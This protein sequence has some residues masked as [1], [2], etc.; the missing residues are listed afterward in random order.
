[1]NKVILTGRLVRE[2]EVRFSA[3][4]KIVYIFALAVQRATQVKDQP[5]ADFL[6]CVAFGTTGEQMQKCDL[7]KGMK[8]LVDGELRIESYTDKSGNKRLATKV[9][10]YRF[11]MLETKHSREIGANAGYA[12][13]EDNSFSGNGYDPVEDDSDVPF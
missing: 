12:N 1:M 8:L 7:H 10:V 5:T 3:A 9:V 11:E 6:D 2:P 13:A 4:G